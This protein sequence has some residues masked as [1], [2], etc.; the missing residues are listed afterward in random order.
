MSPSNPNSSDT[1]TLSRTDKKVAA[2]FG[3][4][5]KWY[6][7]LNHFLSLGMDFYWRKALVDEVEVGKTKRILDLAAGTQDVGKNLCRKFPD[8]NIYASDFSLPMLIHG[9]KKDPLGRIVS[10]CADAK[11]LPFAAESFDCTTISFGIR[12]VSP[13]SSAYAEIFR[14]LSPGGKFCILEFGSGKNRIWGGIYNFYL[15]R[16]L[17]WLG[18]IISRDAS[19]YS[20]LATTIQKFPGPDTLEEELADAGFNN[21]SHRA[22]N[23]GIVYLHTAYKPHG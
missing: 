23:S 6:D 11:S 22:L 3:N 4:I 17:P 16:V 5:A 18:K 1:T 15:S 21:T 14:T 8:C 9:G 13:R 10:V 19:A 7:F 2:M 12:N 20:Y